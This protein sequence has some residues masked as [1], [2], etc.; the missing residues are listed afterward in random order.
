MNHIAKEGVLSPPGVSLE[1]IQDAEPECGSDSLWHVHS[2]D[3]QTLPCWVCCLPSTSWQASEHP[4]YPPTVSL[5]IHCF[6]ATSFQVLQR[7]DMNTWI[8]TDIQAQ[9]PWGCSQSARRGLQCGSLLT[10]TGTR[11]TPHFCQPAS[12][13][14]MILSAPPCPP[15]ALLGALCRRFSD[16]LKWQ[17]GQS[18]SGVCVPGFNV[19]NLFTQVLFPKAVVP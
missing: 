13:Q 10:G 1:W 6:V 16:A 15:W 19:L 8:A 12:S 18:V 14:Q 11:V 4:P 9:P 3:L 7:K 2:V 5:W 17:V